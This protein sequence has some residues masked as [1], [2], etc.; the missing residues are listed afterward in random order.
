MTAILTLLFPFMGVMSL[1][2]FVPIDRRYRLAAWWARY[3]IMPMIRATLGIRSKVLGYENLPAGASVILSKHQSAWETIAFLDI[4]PPIT[5]VLKRELLWIPFF[6]W[7]LSR[8][9]I[10]SI[11][12]SAGKDALR[13]VV[14]D[15]K[16]RLSEGYSVVVFPE[17]TRA[18][19]GGQKRYKIGGPSLAVAAG[20]AVVP[21][22]HNAGEFWPRNAILKYPG[23]IVVSIGPAISTV[24]RTPEQVSA[25][26]E[27]WIEGE[28]RRLFPHHYAGQR[29]RMNYTPGVE[30]R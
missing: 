26:A 13:Q 12:R 2:M 10:V 19:V 17:G 29:S 23:E 30:A 24:G 1:L 18:P 9:P 20:V 3:V 14:E 22:A 11:D 27:A 5:Y 28:M 8:L 15:G 16:Q 6:G 25:E 21:V 7:G 4:F